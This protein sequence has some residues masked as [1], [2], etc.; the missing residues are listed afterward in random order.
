MTLLSWLGSNPTR[1]TDSHLRR[2]ISTSCYIHTVIPPDNGLY[3][4]PKPVEMFDEIQQVK[5][6]Q[7]PKSSGVAQRVP[8]G[9]GSQIS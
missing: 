7:S 3:I 1:T 2:I 8:G 4:C 6:K 5:V 9:L